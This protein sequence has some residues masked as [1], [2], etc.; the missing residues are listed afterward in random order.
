MGIEVILSSL[1]Y[2]MTVLLGPFI[3]TLRVYKDNFNKNKYII[4]QRINLIIQ[5][6]LIILAIASISYQLF[7]KRKIY[8]E[9]TTIIDL[10]SYLFALLFVIINII[11]FRYLIVDY[12][13]PLLECDC[14][15]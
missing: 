1:V 12:E 4:I 9:S 7:V 2:G 14:K 5:L 10:F 13:V 8:Y 11:Y 3:M 15:K 6:L